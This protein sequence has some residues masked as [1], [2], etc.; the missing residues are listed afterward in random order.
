MMKLFCAAVNDSRFVLLRLSMIR[1]SVQR[2]SIARNAAR[3]RGDHAQSEKLKRDGDQRES[4]FE[5]K[6]PGS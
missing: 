5:E 2:F 6:K 4:R 1:K 3:L